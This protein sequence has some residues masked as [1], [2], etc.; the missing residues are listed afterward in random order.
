MSVSKGAVLH[1]CLCVSVRIHVYPGK[2]IVVWDVCTRVCSCI[3]LFSHCFCGCIALEGRVW[4]SIVG[5]L[6]PSLLK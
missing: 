3:E 1:T 4:G 2:Q 6:V 5:V